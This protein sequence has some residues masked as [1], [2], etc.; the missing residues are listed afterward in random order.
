M[1]VSASTSANKYRECLEKGDRRAPSKG[2][3]GRKKNRK[4]KGADEGKRTEKQRK[5]KSDDATLT[6]TDL[7]SRSSGRLR[8]SASERLCASRGSNPG[9]RLR[10]RRSI[11][12]RR[13]RILLHGI[14]GAVI[15]DHDDGV[16]VSQGLLLLLLISVVDSFV[17]V[18]VL[19]HDDDVVVP[20]NDP[21]VGSSTRQLLI[22]GRLGLHVG[23]AR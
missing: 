6:M 22:K 19:C 2:R 3:R 12:L 17:V 20:A 16:A 23:M 13:G 21:S 5:F 18:V 1:R 14:S 8:S 7:P 10:W 11:P 4:S 15:L 9:L